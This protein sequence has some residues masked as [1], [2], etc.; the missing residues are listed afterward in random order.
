MKPQHIKLAKVANGPAKMLRSL[1]QK[2]YD[3]IFDLA[4]TA[5]DTNIMPTDSACKVPSTLQLN[6]QEQAIHQ[7]CASRFSAPHVHSTD[8]QLFK[9]G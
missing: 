6:Q 2:L 5:D 8:I 4:F 1:T 7:L 9:H 3:E